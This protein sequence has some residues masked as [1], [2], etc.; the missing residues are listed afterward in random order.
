MIQIGR[1]M[2][3]NG[4]NGSVNKYLMMGLT[5]LS[6]PSGVLTLSSPTK[7]LKHFQA[8]ERFEA[9]EESPSPALVS[10]HSASMSLEVL[11]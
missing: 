6:I 11:R 9:S 8:A 10:I 3:I 2:E 7:T 4:K 1:S 5:V